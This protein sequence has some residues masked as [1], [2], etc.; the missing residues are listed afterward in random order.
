MEDDAVLANVGY[1]YQNEGESKAQEYLEE[2][3][4]GHRIHPHFSDD[5]S[6]FIES[7]R[8]A[9]LSIPGTN[10]LEDLHTDL[11]VAFGADR[12]PFLTPFLHRR[13]FETDKKFLELLDRYGTVKTVGHSL[14]STIG[15]DLSRRHNQAH[16]GFN[17]GSSPL[18]EMISL[19]CTVFDCGVKP[20]IYTVAGD[21]I[22]MSNRYLGY[23][24]LEYIQKKP[25]ETAHALANFLPT[26]VPEP[27]NLVPTS[28]EDLCTA[29]PDNPLCKFSSAR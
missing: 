5:D 13:F 23:A 21:P 6:V 18:G 29:Q 10:R 4:Q 1:V 28:E 12:N 19:P 25:G 22:S 15:Q 27:A 26:K 7:P 17:P 20:K 11:S 24:D 3:L 2:H 16:T 14:G 8:G 9:I